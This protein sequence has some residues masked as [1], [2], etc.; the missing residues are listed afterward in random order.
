MAVTCYEVTWLLS[1]LKALGIKKLTP[2]DLKCDNQ[3]ALFIAE[4]PE[5]H[6]HSKHIDIDYHYVRDQLKAGV[7]KS[8]YVHTSHQLADLFTKAI[9]VAQHQKL[10]SKLEVSNLFQPPT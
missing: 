7:I 5:F 4:N 10:L 1:L 9:S 2:G 3:A 6:E 8:S